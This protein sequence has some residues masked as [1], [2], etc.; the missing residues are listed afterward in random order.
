MSAQFIYTMHKVGQLKS[1]A[2]L[3][4][5]LE[6]IRAVLQY[7]EAYKPAELQDRLR[8]FRPLVAGPLATR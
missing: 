1:A 4:K 5:G 7:D 3:N 2:E 8:R 6:Q